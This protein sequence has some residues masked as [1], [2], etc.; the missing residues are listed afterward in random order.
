MNRSLRVIDKYSRR[1]EI[2]LARRLAIGVY[3]RQ[4]IKKKS[5]YSREYRNESIFQTFTN[6]GT[7]Y[8]VKDPHT[9]IGIICFEDLI[10]IVG[11][12]KCVIQDTDY[13]KKG[14]NEQN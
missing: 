14:K 13:E 1:E 7:T 8:N 2:V 3:S 10:N 11:A 12:H 6:S 5:K 4:V 9:G